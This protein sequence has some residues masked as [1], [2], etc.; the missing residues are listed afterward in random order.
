MK[1]AP[2]KRKGYLNGT[3]REGVTREDAKITD[4][5]RTEPTETTQLDEKGNPTETKSGGNFGSKLGASMGWLQYAN[6][7]QTAVRATEKKDTL[8]DPVTGKEVTGY[9]SKQDMLKETWAKPTHEV[10][11]DAAKEG[12]YGQAILATNPLLSQAYQYS[13]L[14]KGNVEYNQAL[15]NIESE[16]QKVAAN[17]AKDLAL[18][19]RERG[20]TGYSTASAYRRDPS[21][22]EKKVA[23][24]ENI[25]T[26]FGDKLN[27]AKGGEIVGKGTGTS[28]SIEAEVEEGSFVV[29][30]KHA[31]VGKM[32]KESLLKKKTGKA[33]LH[34]KDG[35]PVKLSDGEILFTKDEKEKIESEM[36]EEML[37]ALAPEAEENEERMAKGGELSVTKARKIL[38]NK[39]VNGKPLTDK[40]KRYFGWIIGGRKMVTGGEVD[41]TV[42]NKIDSKEPPVKVANKKTYKKPTTNIFTKREYIEPIK[43]NLAG[44]ETQDALKETTNLN[45]NA[46]DTNPV[47]TKVAETKEPSSKTNFWDKV[48]GGGAYDNLA[49]IV[50]GALNYGLSAYQIKEGKKALKGNVR[51][52]ATLDPAFNK[53]VDQA[54]V[55]QK[56]GYTPEQQFMLDQQNQNLLN[57]EMFAAKN[58]A[59]GSGGNAFNMSRNAAN[60]AFTRSLQNASAN[61][62][63]Q[64]SKQAVAN[65][66][67]AQRAGMNRVIFEDSLQAFKEKEAAAAE[68]LNAGIGNLFQSNRFANYMALR[69][70]ENQFKNGQNI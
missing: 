16:K 43:P 3:E 11:M 68:L 67:T 41:D 63:L 23:T 70:Q 5:Q 37:E 30:A 17:E 4:T 36:G 40:Q 65:Q 42:P 35:V 50:S 44:T 29:P 18:A 61:T 60:N 56:F 2:K 9:K 49:P 12:K 13:K 39:E 25:F 55:N 53:Q 28:D 51:P 58:Y 19:A 52:T 24:K 1:K 14:R 48:S 22:D 69:N 27:F 62:E 57:Q 31:H 38:H 45:S 47:S 21:V 26:K 34:Q 64:M 8:V 66:L 32:I 6:Q 54:L 33:N 20:E 59:G 46:V 7:A 15:E 10:A